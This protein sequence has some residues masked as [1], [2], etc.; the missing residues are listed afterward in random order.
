MEEEDYSCSHNRSSVQNSDRIN[1]IEDRQHEMD[2]CL[3]VILKGQHEM[4]ECL[5][6]ISKEQQD[7]H[8]AFVILLDPLEKFV[9]TIKK[10]Y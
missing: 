9:V 3:K 1:K 4:D 5:R 8:E 2:E 10:K 6:V 7:L